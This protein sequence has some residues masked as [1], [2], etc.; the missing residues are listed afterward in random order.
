MVDGRIN[1]VG[2]PDD[3][4]RSHGGLET[5]DCHGAVAIP[6]LVDC[7]THP[8][9]GGDRAGEFDLRAQGADYE[10]IHAA[11]AGSARPSSATRGLG[12]RG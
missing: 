6:G 4:V 11:A 3:V 10:R 9:F 7:H 5:V 8:A 2:Q 1:A 12:G